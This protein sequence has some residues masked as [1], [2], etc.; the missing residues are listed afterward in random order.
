LRLT[1]A[2]RRIV[3]LI[4]AV[5]FI[6]VLD[7]MIVMPLGPDFARELGIPTSHIGFI[8]GSYSAAGCVA[9]LIASSFLDRFDRRRAL[10]VCMAGLVAGTA[11]GGLAFDLPTLLM[12]R[13]VAGAFGGPAIAVAQAIIADAVAPERRG[14]AMG[15][16]TSAFSLAAVMG[17]PIGLELAERGGWRLPL[18]A[19]AALGGVIVVAVIALLPPMRGHLRDAAGTGA[20][21]LIE[22]VSR[23]RLWIAYALGGLPFFS[24]FLIIPN[25]SAFVQINLEFPR[26]R[27]DLLYLI[28]GGLSFFGTRVAGRV[29]DRIGATPV[30]VAATLLL[31]IVM[32]LCFV[33]RVPGIPV[34]AIFPLFMLVSS[35]RFVA[36]SATLTK[37]PAAAERAGFMSLLSAIQNF[38]STAGS[39]IAAQ[40]LGVRPDG[41]LENMASVTLLSIAVGLAIPVLMWSVEGSI[42]S[43]APARQ[44]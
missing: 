28:G 1:A 43:Q 2:E 16:V 15:A 36:T 39:F 20:A 31:T 27:L 7:F 42:R 41:A 26:A 32:L 13:V 25:I 14:R 4:G 6:N 11:L 9:G 12:A 5:N 22:L 35:C 23:R 44:T 24:V 40:M 17:V 21:T 10:A 19:V 38:A 34:L 37:V 3:F 8:A 29:V 33:T 30:T 18:F